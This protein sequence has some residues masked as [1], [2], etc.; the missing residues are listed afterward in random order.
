MS[1]EGANVSNYFFD[2]SIINGTQSIEARVA[3][4]T[5]TK[6]RDSVTMRTY[7]RRTHEGGVPFSRVF[8]PPEAPREYRDI[9]TLLDALRQSEKYP[10]SQYARSYI[11]SLPNELTLEQNIELTTQFVEKQFLNRG[12]CA[13]VAIHTNEA[14]TEGR[15]TALPAVNEVKENI[16]THIVVP[17]R[18]LNRS[19]F[20]LTKTDSR[21]TNNKRYLLTLRR[22]WADLQNQAYERLG[23]DERVSHESLAAQ[24]IQ[25]IPT[26]PL[27]LRVLALE[28]KGIRTERGDQYRRIMELNRREPQDRERDQDRD[29]DR[30]PE[31]VR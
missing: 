19:G 31:P 11:L 18:G 5:K 20:N 30:E 1:Q 24:G 29:S 8:L 16:H 14:R 9:Q 23:R 10:N 22:D 12:Q 26:V 17:F 3:Y 25:R 4:N 13:I 15:D 28:R 21:D 27:G 7:D 2:V 6:L